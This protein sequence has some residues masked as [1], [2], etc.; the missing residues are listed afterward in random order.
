MKYEFAGV[1]IEKPTTPLACAA[2]YLFAQ[3]MDKRKKL[4]VESRNNTKYLKFRFL[5]NSLLDREDFFIS[6]NECVLT[7]QSSSLRGFIYGYSLFLKKTEYTQDKIVLVNDI[8]G[9]FSP[10]KKI[11]G[12]QLGYRPKNNTYDAW[13]PEDFFS[14]FKDMMFFGSNCCELLPGGTDDAPPNELMRWDPDEMLALCAQQ[15]EQIDLD[16]SIW[17]PNCDTDLPL[18]EAACKREKIFKSVSNLKYVFIPGADPGK[19]TVEDFLDRLYVFSKVLKRVRPMAS[20]WPSVQEPEELP[21]WGKSFVQESCHLS[22]EIEGIISGPFAP[23]SLYEL[24]KNAANQYPIRFYPDIAHNVRC[25][26]PVNVAQSD[27]HFSLAATLG[28]ESINPRPCEFARIHAQTR[29]YT[30]GSVCYSEGVNDDVNKMVWASLDFDSSLSVREILE[31]YARVFFVGADSQKIADGIL[32]LERNWYGDPAENPQIEQTLAVFEDLQC[33]F[34]FL[35]SQWR[36]LL[37]LFRA[38]ADAIVRRRRVFELDLL[39][40]AK[41]RFLCLDWEGAILTLEQVFPESY[42]A[43]RQKLFAVAEKLY[44]NI[45]IQLNVQHFHGANYDRGATLDTIDLPVTNRRYLLKRLKKIQN[46][47]SRSNR[48]MQIQSVQ[49]YWDR[50]ADEYTLDVSNDWLFFQSNQQNN[51]V[52]IFRGDDP[53]YNDGSISTAH[54]TFLKGETFTYRFGGFLENICYMLRIIVDATS[55]PHES[56]WY[57]IANQKNIFEGSFNEINRDNS[58]DAQ[59]LDHQLI[60][61]NFDLFPDVFENGC[62]ELSFGIKKADFQF[63]AIQIVRKNRWTM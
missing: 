4:S 21:G 14:Y 32:C 35:N 47:P 19:M 45:G 2:V 29:R 37:L 15:A 60:S 41:H 40:Q 49:S 26:Y 57:V 8:S 55:F 16:V 17:Y 39:R 44:Q 43:L 38:I 7:L 52:K 6:L 13:T 50:F 28:R 5:V 31:D 23:L 53:T 1:E 30:I 46:M 36:F 63:S 3:E 61:L 10:E 59:W 56:R 12:H 27:W 25:Q 22:K 24:R 34:P 51:P 11:R 48:Q 58:Y 33:Q 9:I 20:I 42:L 54:L 18:E 62:L